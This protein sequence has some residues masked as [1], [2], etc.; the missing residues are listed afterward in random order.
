MGEQTDIPA[1]PG[2]STAP[3]LSVVG[4]VPVIEAPSVSA[5]PVSP[6][7]PAVQRRAPRD[8]GRAPRRKTHAKKPRRFDVFGPFEVPVEELHTK[9]RTRKPDIERC[10]AMWGKADLKELRKQKGCYVFALRRGRGFLPVYVGKTARTF[11]AECFEPSKLNLLRDAL[12]EERRGTLV[13]FLI[14]YGA[15]V[16]AFDGKALGDLERYLITSA[17]SQNRNLQNRKLVHSMRP[18]FTVPG[19]TD[20]ARGKP[21]KKVL[22]LRRTLGVQAPH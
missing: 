8:S 17:Y 13:V 5:V 10:K 3:G 15:T 19:V 16:G 6:P 11:E 4:S 14:R 21:S 12:D 7:G 18:T 9:P 2:D 20:P 1:A 22:D